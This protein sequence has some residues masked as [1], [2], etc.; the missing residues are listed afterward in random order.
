MP[1]IDIP[2]IPDYIFEKLRQAAKNENRTLEQQAIVAIARGLD[3]HPDPKELREQ[4]LV[5]IEKIANEN[6]EYKLPDPV[7]YIREDRER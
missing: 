5:E 7:K 1:V 6:A 4:S 3:M 2:D